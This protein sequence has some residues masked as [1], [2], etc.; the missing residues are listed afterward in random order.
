M[1]LSMTPFYNAVIKTLGTFFILLN[2]QCNNKYDIKVQTRLLGIDMNLIA[3][4][5]NA[6]YFILMLFDRFSYLHFDI[7]YTGHT[8]ENPVNQRFTLKSKLIL[9]NDLMLSYYFHKPNICVMRQRKQMSVIATHDWYF[10]SSKE[11]YD[12]ITELSW[13]ILNSCWQI[14]AKTCVFTS[15]QQEYWF[16]FVAW[17]KVLLTI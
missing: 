4:C 12:Y 13:K 7:N 2:I 1:H 8:L 5:I 9:F 17:K 15:T 11:T 14:Y 6:L 3:K 16:V 10:P